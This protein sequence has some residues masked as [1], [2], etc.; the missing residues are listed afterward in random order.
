MDFLEICRLS[1]CLSVCLPLSSIRSYLGLQKVG[2]NYASNWKYVFEAVIVIQNKIL[3]FIAIFF[4]GYHIIIASSTLESIRNSQI[5]NT[6]PVSLLWTSSL[7]RLT[8]KFYEIGFSCSSTRSAGF[9]NSPSCCL[10]K[11]NIN[12]KFYL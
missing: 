11:K 7:F 5:D 8:I 6:G 4:E 10:K 12:W 3:K 1:H 2:T 9:Q